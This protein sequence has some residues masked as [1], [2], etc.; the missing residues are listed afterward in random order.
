MSDIE[1]V[2]ATEAPEA[3]VAAEAAVAGPDGVRD[4]DTITV[5]EV[6]HKVADC[7]E[8]VQ[9]L[10]EVFN[11]WNKKEFA[12]TEE[13]NSIQAQLIDVHD[14]VV[15]LKAA[16]ETV[17]RQIL[18]AFKKDDEDEVAPAAVVTEDAPENVTTPE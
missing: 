14:E 11:R 18:D 4:I 5:D 13:L 16:K 1:N 15:I 8:E 12:R 17:S 3:V 7:T 6:Q 10:V 2:E 9:K